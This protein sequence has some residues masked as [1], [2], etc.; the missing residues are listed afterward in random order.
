MIKKFVLAA[1]L[2]LLSASFTAA[3]DGIV[4]ELFDLFSS[5][6]D[7]ILG[8]FS[9][10]DEASSPESKLVCT[11]P[12]ILAGE[13]CCLDRNN[14]RICDKNE[15]QTTTLS[16]VTSTSL[17][18]TTTNLPETTS[19]SSTTTLFI[20]CVSNRDCGEPVEQRVCY[21]G[22][23]HIQRLSPM[24]KNPGKPT[25]YCVTKSTVEEKPVDICAGEC[26][27][28]HAP[29]PDHCAECD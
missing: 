18:K 28:T 20:T 17:T 22:D 3:S 21:H 25:S 16:P 29:S 11:T 6:L 19:S 7:N 13:T 10:G 26:V 14:N 23:V 12:Y 2:L 1:V 27:V 15:A 9:V 24:C 5:I 4:G 8:L